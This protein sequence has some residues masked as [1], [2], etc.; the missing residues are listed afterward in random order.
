[1]IEGETVRAKPVAWPLRAAPVASTSHIQVCSAL[2][3]AHDKGVVHRDIKPENLMLRGDGYVKV[4]DFGVAKLTGQFR[5]PGRTGGRTRD[6]SRDSRG[7]ARR[8]VRVHVTRAGARRRRRCACRCLELRRI[9]VRNDQRPAAFWQRQ[10]GGCPGEG[11]RARAGPA[12][13]TR[14]KRAGGVAADRRQGAD[15]RPSGTLSDD[16][17]AARRPQVP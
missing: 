7:P 3:T 10:R 16:R 8:D 6:P 15:E 9:A 2:A 13:G 1:M 12:A 14:G 17:R 11:P 4:L 5:D